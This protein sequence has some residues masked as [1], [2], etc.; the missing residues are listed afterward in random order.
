MSLDE[1][2]ADA[3]WVRRLA[4]ALV[5][6]PADAEDVAQLTFVAA[7]ERPPAKTGERRRWLATVARNVARMMGRSAARRKRREALPEEDAV[8]S[9]EALVERAQLQRQ[10]AT[11]LTELEEPYR[12]TILLCYLEDLTPSQIAQRLKI[13]AATVRSRLKRGLDQLR[14]R[15]DRLHASRRAGWLLPMT[16][17]GRVTH[18]RHLS[19]PIKGMFV[20]ANKTA[21]AASVGALAAATTLVG[22]YQGRVIAQHRAQSEAVA[23]HSKTQQTQT[24]FASSVAAIAARLP[25][26]AESATR[27]ELLKR[28]AEQRAEIVRLRAEV[29]RLLRPD[30]FNMPAAWKHGED[31][32]KPP[33]D[34]LVQMAKDCRVRWDSPELAIPPATMRDEFALEAGVSDDERREYN[35]VAA[36]FT[37]NMIAQL[38]SLYVEVT[39]DKSGAE[40]LTPDAMMNEIR[41][42]VPE[43]SAQEA[44]WKLSHERAG[45]VPASTDTSSASAFERYLRLEQNAGDAFENSL[46]AVLGAD[47][48]HALRTEDGS[49]G[50]RMMLGGCPKGR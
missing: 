39:G 50:I 3:A 19:L 7:I 35:R 5:S 26:P 10:L 43:A 38:R 27:E 8:P 44:Y 42:K 41:L 24:R 32:I 34:E 20:M 21:I 33:K 16:G 29:D 49:W 28:D 31:Y 37:Q 4:A 6:E 18:A 11:M 22:V 2:L 15:L 14:A 1:L 23:A 45:L 40:T 13:P 48:A 30:P 47:R 17:L 25:P 46:A 36:E 9:P 12:T